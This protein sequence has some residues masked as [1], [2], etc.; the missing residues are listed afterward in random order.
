MPTRY[1]AVD[2]PVDWKLGIYNRNNNTVINHTDF[3]GNNNNEFIKHPTDLK[4]TIPLNGIETLEFSVLITDPIV[5]HLN[6]KTT[7]VRLWRIIDDTVNSI[8]RHPANDTPDYCGV[9]TSV[10]KSGQE[11]KVKIICQSPLWL[12]QNHFHIF[13]HR[14]VTDPSSY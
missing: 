11:G 8:T 13:N 2:T 3:D 6:T 12:I 5:P 1:L 4:V 7:V 10:T 14:L 9:V